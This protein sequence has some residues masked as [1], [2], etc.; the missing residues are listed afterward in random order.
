MLQNSRKGKNQ[1][2]FHTNK[3]WSGKQKNLF[4]FFLGIFLTE[5]TEYLSIHSYIIN[6]QNIIQLK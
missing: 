6:I 3:N 1:T 4:P 2:F 5:L